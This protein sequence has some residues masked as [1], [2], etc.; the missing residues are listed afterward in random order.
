MRGANDKIMN[1][2]RKVAVNRIST[3]MANRPLNSQLPQQ[4]SASKVLFTNYAKS[5]SLID[6]RLF[7]SIR[8]SHNTPLQNEESNRIPL[9]L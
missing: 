4:P 2:Y 7:D 8:N 3:L 5:S 9:T 1:Q 6:K